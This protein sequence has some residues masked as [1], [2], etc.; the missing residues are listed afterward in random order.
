MKRK[1]PN[2]LISLGHEPMLIIQL[3]RCA[4]GTAF[5]LLAVLLT[6]CVKFSLQMGLPAGTQL[7]LVQNLPHLWSQCAWSEWVLSEEYGKIQKPVANDRIISVLQRAL[8]QY[9][10]RNS[11][12]ISFITRR[13]I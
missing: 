1:K 3:R 10:Q 11:V 13:Y 4:R 9:L 2:C 8:S 12:V 6:R 5:L 7:L